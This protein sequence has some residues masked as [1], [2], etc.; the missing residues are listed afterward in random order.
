M[1][2]QQQQQQQSV[3][4]DGGQQVSYWVT[5]L[6]WTTQTLVQKLFS[7][8]SSQQGWGTEMGNIN[9]NS[10]YEFWQKVTIRKKTFSYVLLWFIFIG[11][12]QISAA[13]QFYRDRWMEHNFP[14]FHIRSAVLSVSSYE[15]LNKVCNSIY[16]WGRRFCVVIFFLQG[17]QSTGTDFAAFL[18]CQVCN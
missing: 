12:V 6:L 11:C 8:Q 18:A 17:V 15:N 1:Q 3:G 2:Q 14:A 4:D 10:E 9:L 7:V 5:V 16:E 13:R